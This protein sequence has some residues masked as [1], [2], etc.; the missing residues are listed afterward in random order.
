[1]T[2]VAQCLEQ[3]RH[4]IYLTYSVMLLYSDLF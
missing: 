2:A 1:M 3:I 4:N